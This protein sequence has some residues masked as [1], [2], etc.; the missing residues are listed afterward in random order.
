MSDKT[1]IDY[2]EPYEQQ[3]YVTVTAKRGRKF[4]AV[5][6]HSDGIVVRRDGGREVGHMARWPA[7]VR[8]M[9]WALERSPE[10]RR[11]VRAMLDDID[12]QLADALHDNDEAVVGRGRE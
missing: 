11:D 4:G 3:V 10:M 7:V 12:M 6:A 5:E 2:T 8:A 9:R 1:G